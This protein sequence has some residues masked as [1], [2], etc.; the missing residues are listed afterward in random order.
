MRMGS[1]IFGGFLAVLLF[2]GL[3]TSV[4]QSAL[5][6]MAAATQDIVKWD[7]AVN[8]IGDL[9]IEVKTMVDAPTDYLGTG[10][11]DNRDNY[12]QV[13]SR[14]RALIEKVGG[15]GFT[16][17]EKQLFDQFRTEFD[18]LTREA[19]AILAFENPVG[20]PVAQDHM[21]RMDENWHNVDQALSQLRESVKERQRVLAA[22]ADRQRA[23]SFR[24]VL[25]VAALALLL[26][27]VMSA[28]LARAF[29]RPVVAAAA[30]AH[31]LAEGDLTAEEL[32]VRSRDEVGQ[33]AEAFNKMVRDLREML[34]RVRV[35]TQQVAGASETMMAAAEQTAHANAEIS[36]AI[37]EVARGASEQTA[38]AEEAAE[39]MEKLRQVVDQ[40]ARGAQTQAQGVNQAL[41]I[42]NE[43]TQAIN[44]VA[45]LAQDVSEAAARS[46]KVAEEGGIA[47]RQ[48]VD[49]MA[50]IKATA[51]QAAERV[52]ELGGKSQQIGE[53]VAVIN[54]IADQTNLLALN[55][56][57][58]AARAGEHGKGFAVVAEEV[59]RLA[60]R[61]ARA[62]GEIAEL[63]ESIQRGV[64]AAVS[65]MDAMTRKVE[66]GAELAAGVGAA[67]DHIL[68]A[69]RQTNGH[70]Q[71]ISAA[72][73]ELAAST[74]EVVSAAA[75]VA[76]ITEQNS[77]A[78]E[79][80]AA[81]SARVAEVVRNVA[82]V[83]HKT[84]QAAEEVS[85]SAEAVSTSAEEIRGN[86]AA[87]TRY[88]AGLE[89]LVA[90]FKVDHAAVLGGGD[91]MPWRQEYEIGIK[92]IDAQHR[93]LVNMINLLYKTARG[94]G[95]QV[96]N[97]VLSD[98]VDYVG[99]HFGYEER[100]MQASGYPEYERHKASH[101][102]L[103][104][105]AMQHVERF[106]RGT[107]SLDELLA[108]LVEWLNG[109]IVGEDKR[110]GPHLKA[111]HLGGH[112]RLAR[113][114]AAPTVAAAK[115]GS[116]ALAHPSRR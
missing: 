93:R 79:E 56:A 37:R 11:R 21:D 78:T 34:H 26:G 9:N 50:E 80:M 105:H 106:R 65:A 76:A 54:D 87:L 40:I 23:A 12:R 20:N 1:K 70:A 92:A 25:G 108:F 62:T 53:I 32:R 2:L 96:V 7:G 86:I 102:R 29:S 19:E 58:E 97:E 44:Q 63:V 6:D 17:D 84:A 5:R 14:V 116:P 85:S 112:G 39:V 68:Q 74:G 73:E 100:L 43:M 3:V 30:A 28:L 113:D 88:A 13:L 67:L 55:A 66:S 69:M 16:P 77:S 60:E 4:S 15:V 91:Y 109:H 52:R 89:S 95:G 103:A 31:R 47:V 46:L 48:T 101:E 35:A 81:F 36:A 75:N 8:L 18:K 90:K 111:H 110:Y 115:A 64:E 99:T 33:M 107:G 82:A 38:S 24:V 10:D 57:I 61:S 98:L 59:R 22:A 41:Q 27:L 45:G 42:I 83:S 114:G 94:G 104:A 49:G 72:A 51:M 71:N